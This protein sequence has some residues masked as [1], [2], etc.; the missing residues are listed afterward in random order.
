MKKNEPSGPSRN[1]NGSCVPIV[2]R[3]RRR[4]PPRPPSARA[5]RRVSAG[6][7]RLLDQLLVPPLDRA[8]ALAQ[9]EHPARAVGEH[10]DLDVPRRHDR[11]L[12]VELRVAEGSLRFARRPSGRRLRARRAPRRD[13]CPC[14]R[15]RRRPSAGPGSRPP[16]PQRER[17][18][19]RR[20]A[21]GPGHD[22][23]PGGGQLV[24]RRLPCRPSGPSSRRSGRRRRARCRGRPRRR[25]GFSAR[26]PQPGWTASQRVVVAAAMIEGILR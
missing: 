11:L 21:V 19:S 8:F 23:D 5:S 24:L 2:D 25:R 18:S 7:R 3:P 22:R 20:R 10:L 16:R 26:K 17:A 6:R 13:A 15:R 14:R 12:E 9:G 1:S 4:A